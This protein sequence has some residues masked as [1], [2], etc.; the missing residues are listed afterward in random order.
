MCLNAQGFLRHKDE[1]VNILIKELRP[2]VIGLTE[3]HVTRQIEDHELHI[4]GYICVRGDSESSRTGGV[5]LYLDN[6]VKFE[7]RAVEKEEGNW[8]SV[9]VNIQE[10]GYRGVIMLVYHSPSGSDCRFI[11]YLEDT[12]NDDILRQKVIIMGDFNIDMNVSNYVQV[13]LTR[14]MQAVGC[15]QLVKKPTRIVKDSETI[16]DLVFSNMEV[17]TEVRHE[18]KITDHAAVVLIWRDIKID[19]RDKK[20]IR[21]D[22]KRMDVQ[23][24]SSL[25]RNN[26]DRVEGNS[27]DDIAKS[28]IHAIMKS[29]DLVAPK[30]VVVIKGKWQAAQWFNEAIFRSMRQRDKAYKQARNTKTEE[31]WELFRNLRN[32]TVNVCR[33][34]KKEYLE[35]KLD[36]NRNEPKQMWKVLKEML[37]G[38][39]GSTEYR[40]LRYSGKVISNTE[41]M[42]DIFNNYFVDSVVQLRKK[43]VYGF[44]S[45]GIAYLYTNNIFEEF[46]KIG[47]GN[48]KSTIRKLL[49]KSGTEEGITVKIMKLVG[50]AAGEEIAYVYNRSLQEGV[51]PSEWKESTVVPVPK[52]R[53]TIK[54]E[55]FRPINKL[56]VYEKVL[57]IMVHK[58]LV[59]YL[60]NNNLLEQCQSGFRAKHS[61]ETTLQWVISSWKRVI[62]EGKMIGVI[63][64]DL[65]RAF[66]VVDREI[67]IRKLEGFGLKGTVL[68]WFKSYLENR[69]QRVKFNG[70]LSNA[71]RVELGVP[72]GSVLGPLLF[73]MYINDIVQSINDEC[74]IRLFADDALIYTTGYA[75]EEISDRLNEQIKKIEKWLE[76]NRLSVNVNKTKVMLIRGIRKKTVEDNVKVVLQDTIL[77]LV[78]E[79]KYLGVILDKN[80][81]FSAHV[82]YISKKAGAKLGVMRRIG[83]DLSCNM[84]GTVYRTIVAPLFE[85]CA[86]I[87]VGLNETNK[88]RLQKLQNQG[89]RIILRCSRRERVVN[90]LEALQFMSIKERIEYNVCQLV[91]K[92]VHGICPEYLSRNS[93]TVQRRETRQ[94][95]NI[96]IDKC[97]SR[98]EQKMLWHDGFKM[99]NDLPIEIKQQQNLCDFRRMLAQYIRERVRRV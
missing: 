55:E 63:F 20:I 70:K 44:S 91:Y 47:V 80:L 99:F 50:E 96:Y 95:G 36:R 90:M 7:L 59:A 15:K 66:E 10:R 94:R 77:E 19:E 73:L 89:M 75:S 3:T 57:E 32:R 82:D 68:S 26:L 6:R 58:Q 1:I 72:Q 5:L 4:D 16:I 45:D 39:K 28:A 71:I 27:I 49:N 12:C 13:R 11:D 97:R 40:E 84:R 46:E 65:K 53:G 43:D 64:L 25:V 98:E 93:Q 52:V 81:T 83:R 17:E 41:H 35:N 22:Y 31:D 78:S 48:L 67:L 24:F 34:A 60:E 51:F 29:L 62:G 87:F 18:P 61:C 42:A 38:S 54:I 9:M 21:R 79:I 23:E 85:Y 14:V 92:I 88:Q 76:I 30:K 37:N 8:W 2:E 86:S 56:P 69:T 33:K 74:E